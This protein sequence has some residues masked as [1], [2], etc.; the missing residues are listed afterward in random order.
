V[1]N[2]SKHGV[3][4]TRR[5]HPIMTADPFATL[6]AEIA[7]REKLV[8]NYLLTDGKI[9]VSHPHLNDAVYSYINA[10]GKSLRPA[11]LMFAAGLVGGSETSA[12]PAAAAIEL[13][14]TFTLV[15]DDI[16]DRDELRRGVPTVHVD[17]ARRAAQEYA[18]DAATAQHYGLAVAILAGDIQQ[19]WAASLMTDLHARFGVSPALA[20]NLVSELFRH[21]QT[22]LVAGETYD[23]VL[24]ATP[25]ENVTDKA[26][27]Q[28]LWQKTGVL[29]EFSGKAGAAIGLNEPNYAAHPTVQA[30][31]T[32]TGKCGIAF[33]L[34]DDVLSIVGD[35]AKLG[36][37]AGN[38][39]REGKRTLIVMEALRRASPDDRA[40]LIRTLGNHDATD[41]EVAQ[42]SALLHSC[43]G[44]DYAK[45]IAREYVE[46][47][48]KALAPLPESEYKTLLKAWADFIINREL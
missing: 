21:V 6:K 14:H 10:G 45:T 5:K 15:H 46:D 20:L 3:N 4:R 1:P 25:F 24:A 11:V 17:F 42:A 30:V 47:A 31:A 7:K 9:T 41:A 36:K 26:I 27:L 19:G 29:Y 39:I 48:L 40:F 43:G 13:Y 33:Q 28:M 12:L 22:T 16:I 18:Y 23:I 8:K 2:H 32:F 37:K 38:D 44:I 35:T 34:Q